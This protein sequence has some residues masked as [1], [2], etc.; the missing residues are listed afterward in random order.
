MHTVD[1]AGGPAIHLLGLVLRRLGRAHGTLYQTSGTFLTT[2]PLPREL[3]EW[4]RDERSMVSDTP[5]LTSNAAPPLC[6][7]PYI[8]ADDRPRTASSVLNSASR[9]DVDRL[10]GLFMIGKPVADLHSSEP[11]IRSCTLFKL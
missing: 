8:G 7:P 3:A 6:R 11:F 2:A 10:Q 5:V 1:V 4:Q 9:L